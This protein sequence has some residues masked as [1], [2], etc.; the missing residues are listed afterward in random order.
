[1]AKGPWPE[2]ATKTHAKCWY[3]PLDTPEDA[4]MGLRFTLSHPVTAAIPPGDE[5]LFAMA[6]K[7]A[8][9]FTPL[10]PAEVEAIKAK[11]LA[12][13]SAVPLPQPGRLSA[14]PR[15][16]SSARAKAY[17]PRATA[18]LVPSRERPTPIRSSGS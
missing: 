5:T 17:A 9:G 14:Q 4:A 8:A 18:W 1:M 3:E 15:R 10:S 6:L 2:G 13:G 11:G 12:A 16:S 7:L